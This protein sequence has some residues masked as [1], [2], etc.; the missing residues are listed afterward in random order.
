MDVP[1]TEVV[2]ALRAAVK[3]RERLA[4]E[5][6]R[7]REA[8]HEPVA[9]VGMACRFPGGVATPEDLWRLLADGTDA[10]GD[11]PTDRNWPADLAD[12]GRPGRSHTSRGGFLEDVAGFDAELFGISPREARSMDPQQRLLLEVCWEAAERTGLDPRGLTGT[13]TGVY[14]GASSSGY[15]GAAQEGDGYAVLGNA[16]S[17][18]TGRVA[19]TF[20]LEGPAITVDTACSS[21]LVAIH[22]AV[23][24]LRRDECALALAGGVS[25]MPVPTVFVEFSRQHALSPDGRCKAYAA[26]ADGFGAAE[27]AGVLVLERLS[28]ARR[29]G[30][31]V[32]A[33]LRGTAVNQDGASSRLTAP[34][35]PA[36]ERVIRAALTDAGLTPADVDV[37]EGHG[38]GTAL[39]DPIEIQAL[40]NTYG[41]SRRPDRPLH[42]GS[43]KS[44]I[45]HTQAAAGVAGVLKTVLALR[46]QLLPRTLH[47]DAPT[48]RAD[49][50]SGGIRL[51]TEPVAWPAAG[52]PRRA[53]VSSFGISGTNAHVIVEQPPEPSDATERQPTQVA[54]ATAV[55]WPLSAATR[56]ALRGQAQRLR[57]YA[58]SRP[59][60]EVARGLATRA[61]LRHRLCP[62]GTSA[63][64]LLAGLDAY[65]ATGTGGA[66][67][68]EPDPVWVFPGQGWQWRGM[69]RALLADQPVFAEAVGQV[70]ALVR[71][72]EG[73]SPTEVLHGGAE[74][75]RVDVLQPVLFAVMVGLARLWESVGVR[76]A[77]VVGHSQG[78]IAAAHIA[79]VLTLE[80]AVRVVVRRSRTLAK[81]AVG[82]R[83]ASLAAGPDEV[84]GWLDGV[85]DLVVAAVNSP[86]STVV[87]GPADAVRHLL[88]R[89]ES[90]GTRAR[91]LDVDYASHG[92]L[93]T[94]TRD[95]I[96]TE[97]S[98]IVP[99]P[100]Q[101]PLYSTLTGSLLDGP[102]MDAGY[103]YDNLRNR[104]RFDDAVRALEAAGHT[105]FVEIS[106]H[107][108][109]T[110]AV[111]ECVPHAVVHPT[112]HRDGPPDDW[113]R[114]LGEVWARGGSVDWSAVQGRAPSTDLPTYAFDHR[115]Y[116]LAPTDDEGT[117]TE[118]WRAVQREDA[119]E[120]ADLLALR[121]GSG[122]QAVKELLPAL[123]GWYGERG[124]RMTADSWRHAVV[125]RPAVT[126]PAREVAGTWLVVHRPGDPSHEACARILADY[127]AHAVPVP[128]DGDLEAV[129]AAHRPA[130][131]LSLLAG[132]GP[133]PGVDQP[134]PS[135]DAARS[136]AGTV[137]LLRAVARTD[138]DTPVWSLTRGAVGT[139]GHPVTAPEHALVW[140]LSLVGGLENATGRIRC[141]DVPIRAAD[142][143]WFAD[144]LV[145]ALADPGDEDGLALRPEGRYVRRLVPAPARRGASRPWRPRGTTV[146]TGGTGALGAHVARH[147]ARLGA[148]HLLLLSRH[149]GAAPGADTLRAELEALGAGV[150]VTACDVSDRAALAAVLAAV[151]D[152]RAVTAVVHAAGVLGPGTALT[153]LTS[154]ELDDVLAAKADGAAHLSDLLADH[155]LDAFVLFSSGA[156]VWG[157]V[158]QAAYAA[159]NAYL[160]ALAER[161]RAEGLAA[162]SIAWGS[163]SGG[164]LADTAERAEWM[165]RGGLEPMDPGPA[166]AA[167]QEAVEIGDTTV[168]IARMDWARF[169]EIYC[170]ARPRPLLTELPLTT[171]RAAPEEAVEE[172]PD[173]APPRAGSRFR[174]LEPVERRAALLDLIREQTA[175][176]LGYGEDTELPPTTPFRDLGYDSA[177]GVLLRNRLADA[178]GLRLPA[179]MIFDHPTPHKLAAHLAET[180]DA[181][182][183]E[184][185][186]ALE[187][188]LATSSAE[189]RESAVTR[190][191]ALARTLAPS[192]TS[193]A[194]T[195][196]GALTTDEELFAVIDR[197]LG[198]D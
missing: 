18:L 137:A 166:L 182:P 158:G 73:W 95:R 36:Q 133:A 77:A 30:R 76:P 131:V 43:V 81:G 120:L 22:L 114:A 143:P 53:A 110:A 80:D 107:P 50:D 27:G 104:V 151:P 91:M 174:A 45:G 112:L 69:G 3:E 140:G 87:S 162:T 152:E 11:F 178:T 125:W 165:G 8:A 103:W 190:L 78:E 169:H 194:A 167:L 159:A 5:N 35:G 106:A 119:D 129:V 7:L 181:S 155:L 23:Q 19:Y 185:L 149:G 54:D 105:R 94:P 116:W 189:T 146:I 156:A 145:A 41:R 198:E 121:A 132:G 60:L 196:A 175:A 10:T 135:S 161:R 173:T 74:T 24:A 12:A 9:V 56:G 61:P 141:V 79:G 195:D 70:D 55:A 4:R 109:L 88:E 29:N 147:L 191:L 122:R 14:V 46:H 58:A 186:A 82:G 42:L 134:L 32:L 16:L 168:S 85:P 62:T 144:A 89:C 171:G 136:L 148:P 115:P 153:E 51:L 44:N 64:E 176:L 1:G 188:A 72:S 177:A 13:A 99:G 67:A 38:T 2:A 49:W 28:D 40:L 187:S 68:T 157:T 118:F 26:A 130:G 57:A 100:A 128:A 25:V 142:E 108:V 101:V 63:G 184:Q 93:M 170:A 192:G 193:P 17:V 138:P 47:V 163:W 172:D 139:P 197:E 123:S 180:L 102:E 98:G 90:Q 21:S 39:G 34:N 31:R 111:E 20:G 33:V 86:L 150:T 66:V 164:G 15:G 75:D 97:L 65:L 52:H 154:A 37:V 59:P 96:L 160:D 126:P 83:M 179:A 117:S 113:H 48:P 183:L 6:R 127:G 124:R 71:E 92:P 84:R